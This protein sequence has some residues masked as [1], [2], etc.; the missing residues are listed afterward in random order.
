[1]TAD[2]VQSLEVES[3]QPDLDCARV[4][5]ACVGLKVDVKTLCERSETLHSLRTLE[6]GRRARN[7]QVE[8]GKAAGVDLVDEL[9]EGVQALLA[10]VA[11][12]ALQR[13]DFV[14]YEQEPWMARVAQDEE[15][16]LQEAQRG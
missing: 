9:A 7:E 14:E 16:A 10:H 13:L 2:Q 3:G 6:E 1:L 11:A 5:E 8:A 12:H 15:E 4:V